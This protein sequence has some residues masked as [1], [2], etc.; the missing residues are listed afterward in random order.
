M[1]DKELFEILRPHVLRVSGS[2]NVI[3]AAQNQNAPKGPYG[4]IQ[5]RYSSTERGQANIYYK[6]APSDKVEVDI[7][8]QRVVTCVVEF[9]RDNAKKFA[10][11]LQQMGKRE[12]VVWPLFKAGISIRNVGPINDLTA[13][14]S[15][16]YEERARVE[17]IL[18]MEGSSKY[19]V[20]NIL[21]VNLG[22]ENESGDE[23]QHA[24]IRVDTL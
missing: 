14:Q 3:L 11:R 5:V 10:E 4:S 13:L 12:D 24:E 17:I 6:D 9:Y 15:S 8:P 21:G 22:L 2:S 1:N 18:W 16:N 19:D 7:R 23:I 20:N